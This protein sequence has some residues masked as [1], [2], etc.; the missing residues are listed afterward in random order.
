MLTD[1]L[2]TAPSVTNFRQQQQLYSLLYLLETGSLY[3]AIP[4]F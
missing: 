3:N 4:A 1:E 2:R